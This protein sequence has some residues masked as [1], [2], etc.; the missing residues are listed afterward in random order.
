MGIGER[1]LS[2]DDTLRLSFLVDKS[3][4]TRSSAYDALVKLK[5]MNKFLT[6]NQ[7]GKAGEEGRHTRPAALEKSAGKE[8]LIELLRV[9]PD[10]QIPGSGRSNLKAAVKSGTGMTKEQTAD[11]MA[12]LIADLWGYAEPKNNVH[13]PIKNQVEI[14]KL[15]FQKLARGLDGG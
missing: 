12:E 2:L 11:V 1:P 6:I 9:K 7:D 14:I 15:V 8:R 13:N 4:A 3:M 10:E 5:S